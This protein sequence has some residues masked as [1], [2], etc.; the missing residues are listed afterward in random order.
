MHFGVDVQAVRD[1]APVYSMGSGTIVGVSGRHRAHFTITGSSSALYA[2]WHARLL[3]RLGVGSYVRRGEMVAH[4]MPES[5]H[6]HVAEWDAACGWVDPRRPTGVLRDAG[7][8]ERPTIGPLTAYVADAAAFAPASTFV[9]P[10]D[11]A[12]H[13]TPL[14]LDALHGVVDFRASVI[15]MPAHRMAFQPQLPLEVAAI[16]G[17]LAPPGNRRRVIGSVRLIFD[18][19]RLLRPIGRWH[20]WAFGTFRKNGCYSRPQ[21][22]CAADYVW[23]VGGRNG[24][25]VDRLPNGRYDYCVQAITLSGVKQHRCTPVAIRHG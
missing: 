2:Y 12:D 20:R 3:N 14:A 7:D 24:W 17:Y 23:H 25:N 8:R 11:Q 9:D 6:V 10:A 21:G 19:A 16:R 18:D 5:H 13:S 4:V 22:R 15:D 1:R